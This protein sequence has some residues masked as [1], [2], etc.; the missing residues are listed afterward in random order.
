MDIP[1]RFTGKE[2]DEET[3]LYYYGARYLDSKAS[4]W[5]SA[6][7][8]VGE[9]I[10]EAPV[11]E[12]ARERNGKLPGMGGIYNVINMHLYHYAGNNPIKYTDPDGRSAWENTESW[13]GTKE[14]NF[15]NLY[16]Q[17]V[18]KIAENARKNNETID[19]AD[20]ALIALAETA[21]SMGLKLTI[22]LYD[23]E[24]GEYITVSSSD[25]QFNNKGQF[26]RF[27]RLNM[28]AV[29]LLDNWT[30][31]EVTQMRPGDLVMFDLRFKRD[32][33]YNG[34]TVIVTGIVDA[35]KY[36]I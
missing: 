21:S 24:K 26:I 33:D 10:P 18:I 14:N 6:D 20:I 2:R 13:D 9:Y 1:Y 35:S 3:G 16:T 29:N 22:D 12:E 30:T 31:K 19:C 4:R 25:K 8:A 27:I 15:R 32:P 7:P 5:L 11:N 17:N 23:S 34:H 36:I 28:G